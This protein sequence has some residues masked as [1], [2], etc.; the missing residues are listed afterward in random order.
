MKIPRQ[1]I[2]EGYISERKH[3]ECDYYIYNYTPKAQYE[4]YWN[5][6]TLNCRGL[7]LDGEG[8]II[9]KPFPKFFNYEEYAPESHL[10]ELPKYNS[11]EV[12]E[13]LDGSLGILYR[14]PSGEYRIA[15]RGSFE[16]EQAKVG[17][18]LLHKE[19]IG[20]LLSLKECDIDKIYSDKFTYLFEIIYPE[21]RIVVDYKNARRLVLLAI[22][23]NETGEEYSYDE[24]K[25]FAQNHVW[26]IPDRFDGIKDFTTIKKEMSRDNA[27]GFVVRFDTGLRIKLKF[28]EYVR[29]HRLI[30]GVSN[31]S[32]WDLLRNNQNVDELLD[33][34]PDEFYQ[35]VKNTKEEFENNFKSIEHSCRVITEINKFKDRKKMA[36]YFLQPENKI[37]S[38]VLFAMV[39]KKD[40]ASVIWKLLKPKYSKP[41]KEEECRT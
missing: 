26:L 36:E 33:R 35:W 14:M 31:R 12:V 6:Y 38:S 8:N 2:E 4:Q 7:I 16:S 13:K 5:E 32:I 3:P 37:Y 19:F 1:L 18:N 28:E 27:E 25:E 30:T 22:I 17:T 10:G 40:Y 15:T 29:L 20:G 41:F 23:N 11:F 39:D 9:A 34:V 21:N 24:L